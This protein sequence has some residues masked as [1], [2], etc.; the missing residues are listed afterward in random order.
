VQLPA[1]RCRI[2]L[3]DGGI[4]CSGVFILAVIGSFDSGRYSTPAE[5]NPAPLLQQSRH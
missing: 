3:T 4:F 2:T 1:Y 5:N